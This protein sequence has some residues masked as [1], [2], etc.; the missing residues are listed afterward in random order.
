MRAVLN[1]LL[2]SLSQAQPNGRK[3]NT[4]K[5][6]ECRS[7]D[8]INKYDA[9][10]EECISDLLMNGLHQMTAAALQ[11]V[12]GCPASSEA[13]GLK[14]AEHLAGICSVLSGLHFPFP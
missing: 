7:A 5:A 11:R 1:S 10:C 14:E 6:F 8:Q 12:A 13:S 3:L 9:L 4:F 2:L